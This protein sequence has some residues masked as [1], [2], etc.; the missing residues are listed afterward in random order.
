MLYLRC[1]ATSSTSK[2]TASNPKLTSP[3]SN[4]EGI[5]RLADRFGEQSPSH[6]PPRSLLRPRQ[7]SRC[8]LR[9]RPSSKLTSPRSNAE[10]IRRLADRFGEQSPSHAPPRSLL[11]PR[12]LSRC[13]LRRRP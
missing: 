8:A 3:R 6:A 5:R 4:A 13:A 12:Q 11:R 2:L 9:R 7:L 1:E 10:G